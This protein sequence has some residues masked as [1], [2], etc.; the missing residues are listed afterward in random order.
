MRYGTLLWLLPVVVLL[1]G[2]ASLRQA[3]RD[4]LCNYDGAYK[5]GFNDANER[6]PM[7]NEIEEICPAETR[8]EA[9]RGYREGYEAGLK[10]RTK[11]V[12]LSR[13]PGPNGAP[14]PGYECIELFDQKAC[15]FNCIKD[16]G[17]VACAKKPEHNCV[18]SFDDIVCGMNCRKVHTEVVCNYR[19]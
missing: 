2:C 14:P 18:I 9:G 17:K 3:Q 8:S 12:L 10:Q 7:D 19:E 1:G 13:I 11:D 5:A 6:K 15:G 4:A 16:H